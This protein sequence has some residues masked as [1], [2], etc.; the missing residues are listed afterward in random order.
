MTSVMR[1]AACASQLATVAQRSSRASSLLHGF[2]FMPDPV[3][4]TPKGARTCGSPR[5]VAR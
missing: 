3:V 2:T 4:P 5:R 1:P